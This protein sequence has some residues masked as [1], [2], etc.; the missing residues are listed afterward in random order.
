MISLQAILSDHCFKQVFS[1]LHF[2]KLDA[3][4]QMLLN[5]M[6]ASC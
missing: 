1:A 2:Y 3:R 6:N 5:V 4:L